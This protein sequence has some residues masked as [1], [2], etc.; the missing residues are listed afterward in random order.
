[1]KHIK[2]AGPNSQAILK[3]SDQ[4]NFGVEW[5]TGH[6]L[7]FKLA[8]RTGSY[9]NGFCNNTDDQ[10]NNLWFQNIKWATLLSQ[11]LDCQVTMQLGRINR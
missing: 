3:Y 4:S 6:L 7:S 11:H 8:G 9:E 1:M 2:P 5:L 10:I